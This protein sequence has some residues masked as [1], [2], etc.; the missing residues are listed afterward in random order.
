MVMAAVSLYEKSSLHFTEET[1]NQNSYCELLRGKLLPEMRAV[2]GRFKKPEESCWMQDGA[3]P[4]TANSTQKFLLE[5]APPD[6]ITKDQ[7][8]SKSPDVNPYDY[9]L[10]KLLRAVWRNV[11]TKSPALTT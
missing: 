2:I 9:S 11:G 1:L 8:P 10:W 6:F 3:T 4:H 7:W 5:A